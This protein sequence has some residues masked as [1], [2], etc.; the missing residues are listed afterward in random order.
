VGIVRGRFEAD[1]SS[2]A[3]TP[4]AVQPLTGVAEPDPNAQQSPIGAGR[5]NPGGGSFGSG[6]ERAIQFDYNSY[7]HIKTVLLAG[8]SLRLAFGVAA[9]FW[10]G[11]GDECFARKLAR[12]RGRVGRLRRGWHVRGEEVRRGEAYAEA[13]KELRAATTR[14]LA[15]DVSAAEQAIHAIRDSYA[16]GHRIRSWPG[17]LPRG[18]TSGAMRRT[19]RASSGCDETFPTGATPMQS[20]ETYL[21]PRPTGCR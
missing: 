14:A 15:G 21:C 2:V 11:S 1:L 20:S 17:R 9:D 16:G 7:M 19:A 3:W 6:G 12:N 18:L 13:V 4:G 5:S 10:H 8:A